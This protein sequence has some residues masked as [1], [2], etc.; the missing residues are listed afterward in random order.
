MR[1]PASDEAIADSPSRSPS[2]TSTS[3]PSRAR[4]NGATGPEKLSR[5]GRAARPTSFPDPEHHPRVEQLL[6]LP[7]QV[8]YFQKPRRKQ[9][10]VLRSLEEFRDVPVDE[11]HLRRTLA[12]D[13]RMLQIVAHGDLPGSI[14]KP[15]GCL[16]ETARNSRRACR[17]ALAQGQRF[18]ADD[19]HPLAVNGIEAAQ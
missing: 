16:E 14:D 13:A 2:S 11:T 7:H 8:C 17:Q 6:R 15:A 12:L 10:I 5:A 9:N 18:G 4:H 3:M 19:R 1:R